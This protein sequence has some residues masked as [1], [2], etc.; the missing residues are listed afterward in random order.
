MVTVT[1]TASGPLLTAAEFSRLVS[2]VA[3]IVPQY[4][5]ILLS[6]ALAYQNSTLISSCLAIV[7]SEFQDCTPEQLSMMPLAQLAALLRRDDLMVKDEG[8]VFD[9]VAK[10]AAQHRSTLTAAQ[11]EDLWGCVRFIYL[12]PTKRTIAYGTPTVPTWMLQQAVQIVMEHKRSDWHKL[13]TRLE[14]EG[15]HEALIARLS[16]RTRGCRMESLILADDDAVQGDFEA[17]LL[18]FLEPVAPGAELELLYRASRDGWEVSKFHSHCDNKG[19]TLL[20]VR[21][22]DTCVFGGYAAVPWTSTSSGQW[23]K[24]TAADESF[25]FSL[26]DTRGAAPCKMLRNP[27]NRTGAIH[28]GSNYG[29]IFG[30]GCDI[31]IG[32][33]STPM[34]QAGSSYNKTSMSSSSGYKLPPGQTGSYYFTASSQFKANEIEVFGVSQRV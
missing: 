15:G 18:E 29:P 30:A 32:Y 26:A 13:R 2:N 24:S 20:L 9:V 25:I 19:Q 1:S 4:S 17:K 33:T 22:D 27:S 10:Y 23:I 14:E 12:T 6:W 16:R 34:N 21:A 28:S 7:A 3:T 31:Q 5:P 11:L 8:Q